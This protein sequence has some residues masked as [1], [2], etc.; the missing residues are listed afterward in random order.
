M[1]NYSW[2]TRLLVLKKVFIRIRYSFYQNQVFWYNVYSQTWLKKYILTSCTSVSYCNLFAF[3]RQ[4]PVDVVLGKDEAA[5]QIQCCT[6]QIVRPVTWW[7]WYQQWQHWEHGG[8]CSPPPWRL[9][10]LLPHP[11]QKGK[12]GKNQPFLANFWISLPQNAIWPLDAP[13]K[14]LVLPLVPMTWVFL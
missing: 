12:N 2:P 11:C 4:K 10:P 14:I 5:V 6:V 8:I 3:L 7:I 9:C 13:P 1:W